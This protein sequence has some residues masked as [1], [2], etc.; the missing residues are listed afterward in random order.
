MPEQSG[1]WQST[2]PSP[3][4]STLSVQTSGPV[5]VLPESAWPSSSPK[6]SLRPAGPHAT[7]NKRQL[8][9]TSDFNPVERLRDRA[10]ALGTRAASLKKL[11]DAWQ[12]LYDSLDPSQKNRLRVLAVLV[13]REMRDV[14]ESRRMQSEDEYADEYED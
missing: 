7:A 2:R 11:A 12:P 3:S 5:F 1:S 4:L 6:W 14:I 13:L 9:R 10:D 8:D